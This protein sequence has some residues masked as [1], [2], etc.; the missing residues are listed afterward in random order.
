M[1]ES[2][3]KSLE[4]LT[5]SGSSGSTTIF[6]PRG[7]ALV[8]GNHLAPSL[9]RRGEPSSFMNTIQDQT[10]P[11]NVRSFLRGDTFSVSTPC[12]LSPRGMKKD[13]KV[14]AVVSSGG[15]V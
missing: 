14:I 11:A 2:A 5:R 1:S 3:R 9:R 4:I 8:S 10:D 7:R 12:L 15:A 13:S 6:Q